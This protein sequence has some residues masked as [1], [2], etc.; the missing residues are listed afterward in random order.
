MPRNR[1]KLTSTV[2]I[3]ARF[4][5]WCFLRHKISFCAFSFI[6][7]SGWDWAGEAQGHHR[8]W[9][10]RLTQ[11]SQDKYFD[12]AFIYRSDFWRNGGKRRCLLMT[13]IR[14]NLAQISFVAMM[15]ER[16]FTNDYFDWKS[17]WEASRNDWA[18]SSEQT[19]TTKLLSRSMPLRLSRHRKFRRDNFQP[20]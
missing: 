8:H 5:C 7:H 10:V 16:P 3:I 18:I 20:P 17:K 2:N 19:T 14:L 6:I 4:C 15:N 13:I 1:A 12:Y 9:N 11:Q